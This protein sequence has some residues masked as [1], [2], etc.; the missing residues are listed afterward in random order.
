MVVWGPATGVHLNGR[1][2]R[3]TATRIPAATFATRMDWELRGSSIRRRLCSSWSGQRP[4]L[5]LLTCKTGSRPFWSSSGIWRNTT[6]FRE[7][8]QSYGILGPSGC[9][10]LLAVTITI[11]RRLFFVYA[12]SS[13]FSYCYYTIIG[14]IIITCLMVLHSI[15]MTSI[16]VIIHY[17][18][19]CYC[20]HSRKL[21]CD[22]PPTPK[23][24]EEGNTG[25]N[26]P[27]PIF[28]LFG[29]YSHIRPCLEI[30]SKPALYQHPSPFKGPPHYADH[31]HCSLL[32][33]GH[34]LS[35]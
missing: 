19:C 20:H 5:L 22:C 27:R 8:R 14:I 12:S 3:L 32:F 13:S 30:S 29:V 15:L 11:V 4:W 6:I 17:Y 26:R 35:S 31:V 34:S 9:Q 16:S 25:T 24:R 1:P 2:G 18:C 33:L 23:P 21:E 28:Q 7:R 10:G